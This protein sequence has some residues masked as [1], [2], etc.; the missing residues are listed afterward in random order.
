ML[1]NSGEISFLND[2]LLPMRILMNR[3]E[4]PYAG[5]ILPDAQ[6][7]DATRYL[8]DA[9]AVL[10]DLDPT[11]KGVPYVSDNGTTLFGGRFGVSVEAQEDSDYGPRILIKVL[12]ADGELPDDEEAAQILS[13]TVLAALK[14]SN[15]DI[16]EWYA[17]DVLLSSED[18][19]RLRSYVSPRRKANQAPE[20]DGEGPQV[21][22]RLHS[23]AP[24]DNLEL[25]VPPCSG[26]PMAS[27][28]TS[29]PV[30]AAEKR[31][32]LASW[33]MT[34]VLSF[35]AAPIGVATAVVGLGRGLDFRMVTQILSV[36]ALFAV[37]LKTDRLQDLMGYFIQ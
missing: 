15:A 36:T 35:I 8:N 25:T 31:M 19:I 20:A 16:I 10:L 33:L 22:P 21:A 5:L 11:A 32:S 30:H 17:P 23:F 14:W 4:F 6:H 9:A 7:L 34:G 27:T 1:P 3:A 2:T 24:P 18:F 12:S 29:A 37:L 13:D 26:G 28:S